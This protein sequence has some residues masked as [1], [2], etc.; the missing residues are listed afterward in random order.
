MA[1]APTSAL[2]EVRL[3]EASGKET[4]FI[5][6]YLHSNTRTLECDDNL[7]RLSYRFDTTLTLSD[8]NPAR[9]QAVMEAM[10]QIKKIECSVLQAAFDGAV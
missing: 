7:C 10:M 2:N 3:G 6:T 4:A 5:L 8:E 9:S 1:L